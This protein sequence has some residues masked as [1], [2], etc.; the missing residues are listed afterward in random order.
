MSEE[1]HAEKVC[2]NCEKKFV[3][4]SEDLKFLDRLNVVINKNKYSFPEPTCCPD[5]RQQRRLAINNET[6]LYHRK[7]DFSGEQII[8]IY[9]ADKPYKVYKSDIWWSDKWDPISYGRPF[10]FNSSFFDQFDDLLKAIPHPAVSTNFQ[11]DENSMYTNYAGS[12]KNCYLIF[13]ADVNRDCYYGYGLKKCESS[14]DLYNVFESELCY[15]CVDCRKCYQLRYSKNCINCSDSFFLEDCIGCKNCIC[16]KNL[17]QKQYCIFNRQLSK[18][19]YEEFLKSKPLSSLNNIHEL[20]EKWKKFRLQFPFRDVQK[21]Q[22]ENSNGDQLFNCRNVQSSFDIENLHDGRYCYQLYNGAKD[23]MDVYQFG[24]NAELCYESSIVGYNAF[25]LHFCQLCRE[26]VSDLNYCHECSHSSCLFGCFG[27]RQ[28]KYCILNQQYSQEEYEN[29]VP[30]II[31][32]MKKNGEWGEFFPTRISFFGYNETTAQE[33]FP[34][35]REQALEKGYKWH[36]EE[37]KGFYDGPRENIRDDI[38]QVD[39]N[40]KNSVLQCQN[41][42]KSYKIIAGEL[43]FYQK[44][45]IPLPLECPICRHQKRLLSRNPRKLFQRTCEKC[46]N[47]IQTTFAP[48]R[49]EIVYCETCYK[50]EVF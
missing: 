40:I 8:S 49:P 20:E 26:Q 46:N 6:R 22:C 24:L 21:Y 32:H 19:E 34:L 30:R 27:L 29:L 39:E 10:D 11:L 2:K 47:V 28:K 13:H 31:E 14:L 33:Y 45:A 5:C 9:S 15:Q 4:S 43:K 17:H 48:D 50:K 7:C 18:Q 37:E 1:F 36:D 35:G 16:C 23:C 12:N 44:M 42:K 38:H 41:C 3:L 25:G